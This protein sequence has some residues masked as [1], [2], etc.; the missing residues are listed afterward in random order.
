MST[1]EATYTTHLNEWLPLLH[2]FHETCITVKAAG[3]G[4]RFRFAAGLFAS[5][6][7]WKQTNPDSQ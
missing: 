2:E 7:A 4:R 6:A 1:T 3:R 5:A